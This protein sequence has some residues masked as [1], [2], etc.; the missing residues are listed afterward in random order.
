VQGRNAVVLDIATGRTAIVGRGALPL[1]GA[2]IEGPGL[3]YAWTSESSGV[4]RFVMTRQV[5]LALGHPVA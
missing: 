1:V 3:A 2:Q 5:D 4:A